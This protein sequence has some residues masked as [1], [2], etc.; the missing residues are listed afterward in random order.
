MQNAN[1][2]YQGSARQGAAPGG[3]T[4]ISQIK[5]RKPL[6]EEIGHY[7]KLKPASGGQELVG[8]CCFHEDDTPSLYVNPSEGTYCCRG[9]GAT[10]NVVHFRAH[11]SGLDYNDAK[12]ELAKELGLLQERVIDGPQRVLN[13]TFD[14]YR[15]AFAGCRNAQEYAQKRGISP[16][17]VEKF[18]IGYCWG[19]EFEKVDD[20][21][22][23]DAKKAGLYSEKSGRSYL[24][25]RLTFPI[26]KKDGEVIAFAGRTLERSNPP[27]A[28][29]G[30]P[31]RKPPPKY[32]N[33][34]ETSYFNKSATLYGLYESKSGI[35]K[36]G[37]AVA[38]EGYMDVVML[39]QYGFD[40]AVGI[41]G[42]DAN[43]H[44]FETLWGMTNNLVFCLDGD[45]AGQRGTM[46]TVKKAALAMEDG[47]SI[48]VAFLP[49]DMDPDEFVRAHGADAFAE[50]LGSPTPLS[51]YLINESAKRYDLSVAE[52]RAAFQQE[53]KEAVELFPNAPRVAQEIA[54]EAEFVSMTA[55]I[56]A[57]LAGQG[58]ASTRKEV[59][60]IID[61]LQERV[62]RRQSAQTDSRPVLNAAST[63]TLPDAAQKASVA[64]PASV[65]APE[66]GTSRPAP[67]IR[68]VGFQVG[69]RTPQ[70]RAA[71]EAVHLVQ[72]T[73]RKPLFR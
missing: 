68:R 44:A 23:A 26:R 73:S 72:A 47:Q 41:M 59:E 49:N 17:I 9:C 71:P 69:A 35:N 52:Q 36:A 20:K 37:F 39:H 3:E 67:T 4:L 7:V 19:N 32:L 48:A 43:E 15:R 33:T 11:M 16:E 10:G 12:M 5:R 21:F 25:G 28:K 60:A 42:A 65:H 2:R 56:K 64:D 70:T 45:E 13:M 31:E 27:Q 24:G 30:D 8:K 22:I 40:N 50:V 38:V 61:V 1:S 58:L 14:R 34:P 51:K 18:G 29:P 46:R 66:L 62:G 54:R 63:P 6:D 53:M 57:T 55:I